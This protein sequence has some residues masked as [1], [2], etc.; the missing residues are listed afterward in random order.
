[1]RLI[2]ENDLPTANHQ[3][4]GLHPVRWAGIVLMA[5]VL[6]VWDGYRRAPTPPAEGSSL[7]GIASHP[8]ATRATTFR[9]G[10]FN[11]DGGV[12]TDEKFDLKRIADCMAGCDLVGLQEAHGRSWTDSRDQAQVLGEDMSLPWLYAPS[13]TQWWHNSFGNAAISN[14]PLQSWERFPISGPASTN[15]RALLILHFHLGDKILHVLVV[16][17]PTTN[18]RPAQCAIVS[19]LFYSFEKPAILLGDLNTRPGDP[20]IEKVRNHAD[21]VDAVGEYAEKQVPNHVDWIFARGLVCVGGGTIDHH[22]S[23]HPFYWADFKVP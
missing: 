20:W 9:V 6:V 14:L 13:E 16:H 21:V 1:M 4:L 19:S 11:I 23:D 10:T 22:A 2:T 17:L 18:D 7:N 5:S 8:A 3:F 15:N 12:G